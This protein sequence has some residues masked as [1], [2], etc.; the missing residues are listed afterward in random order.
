MPTPNRK[1]HLVKVEDVYGDT[2]WIA[3]VDLHD[4]RKINLPLYTETGE[5]FADT[6]AAWDNPGCAKHLHREN[7]ARV[8]EHRVPPLTI[9]LPLQARRDSTAIAYGDSEGVQVFYAGRATW[10]DLRDDFLR[11]VAQKAGRRFMLNRC[12]DGHVEVVD[13]GPAKPQLPPGGLFGEERKQLDL[14]DLINAGI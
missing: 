6:P 8:L 12:A 7:V 13:Y 10:E 1:H 3:H 4:K 11:L 2:W 14:V 9:V 5:R